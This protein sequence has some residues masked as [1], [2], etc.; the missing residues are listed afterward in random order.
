M[1]HLCHWSIFLIFTA[2]LLSMG[3][4][5]VKTVVQTVTEP[6]QSRGENLLETAKELQNSGDLQ[7]AESYYTDYLK[8]N[9]K[10]AAVADLAF[11]NRQLA[12]LA[13]ERKDYEAGNR[14]FEM[15][16][17]Y[18]PDDLEICG[19]YGES[20]LHLQKDYPKAEAVFRQ[21]LSSAPNDLRF[22]LLLGRTL[23]YQKKYQMGLKHLKTALGEKQA[24]DE[25]A[26][27][28]HQNGEYERAALAMT[29][30][31]EIQH[32]KQQLAQA[33]TGMESG[34]PTAPNEGFASSN[35]HLTIPAISVAA[36]YHDEL[37]Q[38]EVPVVTIPQVSA[39]EFQQAQ[40]PQPGGPWGETPPQSQPAQIIAM[41]APVNP[42]SV[43]P[44]FA[45]PP[46]ADTTG[47]T[48]TSPGTGPAS[49][50]FQTF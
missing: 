25:L 1:R 11:A 14:Y 4:S 28:Y 32:G 40:P 21:A 36:P 48:M 26:Q 10:R 6:S 8:A 2:T 44:N 45:Q 41:S 43:P 13:I 37:Q 27:I 31:H 33:R 38:Q 19:M 39:M 29:K 49:F 18:T 46:N 9:S 7:K 3:C 30:S 20:L 47:T 34:N 22:Q 35:S 24:Y 42:L 16:L 50:G 12:I 23:A 5:Y 15:A 17:H